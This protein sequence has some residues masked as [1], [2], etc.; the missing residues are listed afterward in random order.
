MSDAPINSFNF[1]DELKTAIGGGGGSIEP[2]T[3]NTL[4]TVYLQKVDGTI[5]DKDSTAANATTLMNRTNFLSYH[6]YAALRTPIIPDNIA[7]LKVAKIPVKTTDIFSTNATTYLRSGLVMF[8]NSATENK[9][10]TANTVFATGLSL[11]NGLTN[12][13]MVM[14]ADGT[15]SE[16]TLKSA[17]SKSLCFTAD[18]TFPANSTTYVFIE[19]DN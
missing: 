10:L 19:E 5:N 16:N 2:A 4:G 6:W 12:S 11:Q 1:L 8:G 15:I 14:R 17:S 18:I 13:C 3:V 9:T 7:W